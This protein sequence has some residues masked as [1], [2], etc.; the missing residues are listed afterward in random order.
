MLEGAVDPTAAGAHRE[1]GRR[2]AKSG[3]EPLAREPPV[4]QRAAELADPAAV[5]AQGDAAMLTERPGE[6]AHAGAV[7][8]DHEDGLGGP[9]S[10]V[11]AAGAGRPRAA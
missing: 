5:D 6:S 7:G 1:V 11:G 9:S 2:A 8:A 3:A 10:A 4:L